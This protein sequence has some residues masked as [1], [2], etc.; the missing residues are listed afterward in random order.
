MSSFITRQ[1]SVIGGFFALSV[2]VS[3]CAGA[4][5]ASPTGAPTPPVSTKAAAV[6]SA[7]AKPKLSPIDAL[8]PQLSPSEGRTMWEAERKLLRVC[9]RAQGIDYTYPAWEVSQGKQAAEERLRAAVSSPE[10]AFANPAW[11]KVH[12]YGFSETAMRAYAGKHVGLDGGPAL[13]AKADAAFSG[14]GPMETVDLGNGQGQLGYSTTGCAADATRGL[15]GDLKQFQ[16]LSSLTSNIAGDL[17]VRVMADPAVSTSLGRWRRCMSSR[18]WT[19][20]V[21]KA[22][23]QDGAYQRVYGAYS[24]KQSNARQLELSIAP[25]D[26]ECTV[27]SGYGVSAAA[28]EIV[29]AKSASR[30]L[31]GTIAPFLEMRGR[32][33]TR[34][35]KVLGS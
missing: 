16:T 8:L 10:K 26:A 4:A 14:T 25:A 35:A 6:A 28:A 12:G 20:L 9:M 18:G 29:V 33:L 22:D 13:S 31:S 5:L 24:S 34:A 15:Y 2:A 30:R 11:A 21:D 3:G 23:G 19:T 27:S 32:A 17:H 7:P 1:T